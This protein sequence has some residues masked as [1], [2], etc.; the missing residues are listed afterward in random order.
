VYLQYSAGLT[1]SDRVVG[2]SEV[3]DL[4]QNEEQLQVP[5]LRVATVGMTFL[6]ACVRFARDS[7]TT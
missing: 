3:C 4:E 7:L 1:C 2:Y 5:P 6:Q